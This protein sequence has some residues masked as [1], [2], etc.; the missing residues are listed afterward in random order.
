MENRKYQRRTGSNQEKN[1]KYQVRMLKKG[2]D[3]NQ[4]MSP[5]VESWRNEV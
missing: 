5:K 1:R 2:P 3:R 4:S